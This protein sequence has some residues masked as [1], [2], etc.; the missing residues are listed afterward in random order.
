MPKQ[1]TGVA[2][3]GNK[4]LPKQAHTKEGKKLSKETIT[5]SADLKVKKLKKMS[6]KKPYKEHEHADDGLPE[7]DLES[8]DVVDREAEAHD[9][10]KKYNEKKQAL[11]NAMIARQGRDPRKVNRPKQLKALNRLIEMRI[12]AK[13]AQNLLI[14][15]ETSDY[16]RGKLEKP[17]FQTVVALVEKRG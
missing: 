15:L 4:E 10:A 5:T 13:E 1:A 3:T 17:D 7:V 2:Q 8:G 9:K 12:T 6:W 14:E 11:I 16:W